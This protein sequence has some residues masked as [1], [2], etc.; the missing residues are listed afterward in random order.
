MNRRFF[1]NFLVGVLAAG[2]VIPPVTTLGYVTRSVIPEDCE[3]D[4]SCTA[5]TACSRGGDVCPDKADGGVCTCG[6]D[7]DDMAKCACNG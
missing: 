6:T 5:R 2:V 1:A 4:G 7:P 3:Q